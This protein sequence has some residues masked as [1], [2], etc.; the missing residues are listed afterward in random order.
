MHLTDVERGWHFGASTTEMDQ[1]VN[2]RLEDMARSLA[3]EAPGLWMFKQL[4]CLSIM[5]C[6]VNQ[7]CNAL[8][9]I[10]GVFLKS[11]NT[12]QRVIECLHHMGI[13]V[14]QQSILFAINSLSQEATDTIRAMGQTLTVGYTYDN[15]DIDFKHSTSTIENVGDTLAHLTAGFVFRLDHGATPDMFKC[16]DSLYSHNHGPT[17]FHQYRERYSDPDEI[18]KIPVVKLCYT[19]CRMMDISEASVEGNINVISSLLAQAGV[20]DPRDVSD[21]QAQSIVDITRHVLLF[22]GDLGTYERVMSILEHRSLET[23]PVRRFQFMVFIFGLFHLKMA[24][25]D[26]IWRIFIKDKSSHSDPTSLMYFVSKMRPHDSGKIAS[27]PRFRQMHEVITRAGVALRLDAWREAASARNAEWTTLEKFA[28]SQPSPQLLEEMA[29]ELVRA[30]ASSERDQVFENTGLLHRYLSLYEE[31][32][33]GMNSGDIGRV[34]AVY[35]QWTLLFKATGKHKYA[36]AIINSMR[37]I[38]YNTLVNPTGQPGKFRA[39]DWIQED[40]NLKTK[41]IHG[42]SNSNYTKEHVIKESVLINLYRSC[43]ANIERNFHLSALTTAHAPADIAM[44]MRIVCELMTA[45]RPNYF[46]AGRKCRF[47]VPDMINKGQV[48]LN[49]GY[50]VGEEQ[51]EGGIDFED[52]NEDDIAVD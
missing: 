38:R 20:G 26:A 10:I 30:H 47:A 2:F 28:A 25:A 9:S 13:S 52:I 27:G 14:S 17:Y 8:Q 49:E 4:V 36:A 15:V 41:V 35:P 3:R 43:H 16:S 6:S 19:P 11:C 23:T 51:A 31:L 40:N 1:I 39:L 22:H 32:S 5:M 7:K 50:T 18:E 45:S 33:Y 46:E 24:A 12:P 42:G 34:E 44:T 48:A 21:S 37:I 29:I